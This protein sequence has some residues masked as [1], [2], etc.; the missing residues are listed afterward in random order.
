[1]I[2]PILGASCFLWLWVSAT[3]VHGELLSAVNVVNPQR[4]EPAA[5]T[6]VLDGLQSAGVRSI[7]VPLIRPFP[8]AIAFARR[9]SERGISLI[10]G[11]VTNDPEAVQP[12]VRARPAHGRNWATNPL[13]GIDPA[14]FT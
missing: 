14:K 3:I 1:M 7:R 6:E 8:A 10:L 12:G 13:S 9:A 5:Q 2:R 11:I 4:M